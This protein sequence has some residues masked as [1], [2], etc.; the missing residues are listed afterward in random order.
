LFA[1]LLSLDGWKTAAVIFTVLGWTF[2][3]LGILSAI[4]VYV[5][6]ANIETLKEAPRTVAHSPALQPH[7]QVPK[8]PISVIVFGYGEPE[9]Y[10]AEIIKGL[11]D[12]SFDVRPPMHVGFRPDAPSGLTVVANGHDAAQL[13]NSLEQAKIPYLV[14]KRHHIPA[15]AVTMAADSIIIEIGVK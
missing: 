8:P 7:I 5:A 15:S 10:A 14:G 6:K 3:A 9:A 13:M 12:A 1:S 11:R 4:A 2:G